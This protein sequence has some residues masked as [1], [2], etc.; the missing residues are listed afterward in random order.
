MKY[1]KSSIHTWD[2]DTEKFEI[3][4]EKKIYRNNIKKKILQNF[5]KSVLESV[6]SLDTI[7]MGSSISRELKRLNNQI[8][9]AGSL[10]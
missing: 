6:I 2:N 3:R 8:T 7:C 4:L 9:N 5:Y 1:H 10:L